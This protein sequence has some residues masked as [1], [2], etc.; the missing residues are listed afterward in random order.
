MTD[1]NL[2]TSGS[3]PGAP[4]AQY[5][6]GFADTE[7]IIT[8]LQ[9]DSANIS[10]MSGAWRFKIDYIRIESRMK[11]MTNVPIQ[12]RLYDIEARRD[13]ETASSA[14]D[15]PSASWNSGLIEQDNPGV[16]VTPSNLFP[17]AEPFESERFTK[18][19]KV[20]KKTTFELGAGSEHTHIISGRP[21]WIMDRALT[22]R[23][24]VIGRRTR[25]LM[26]V[27]EG[28]VTHESATHANISYSKHAVDVVTEYKARFFSMEK[29]RSAYTSYSS[30][31]AALT[32]EVTITE[33]TDIAT[34]VVVA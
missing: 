18:R 12:I 8:N 2:F 9:A 6:L 5:A 4:S 29:A 25:F 14:L 16:G 22:G 32:A 26:M 34:P 15:L 11:N 17:G 30:M 24:N 3:T 31:P 27:V 20:L 10:I 28:G 21:P 19:F 33:D 1:I 23:Y 7:A 13:D